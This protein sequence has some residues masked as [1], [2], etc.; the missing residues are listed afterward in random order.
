MAAVRCSEEE[1]EANTNAIYDKCRL[2]SVY[3]VDPPTS[4]KQTDEISSMIQKSLTEREMIEI[5]CGNPN[6]P[7]K[8]QRGNNNNSTL[9]SSN[10]LQFNVDHHPLRWD[11]TKNTSRKTVHHHPL[12]LVHSSVIYGCYGGMW[13]CDIHKHINLR[14]A[15]MF[16]CHECLFDV[17]I[18][19]ISKPCFNCPPSTCNHTQ[20]K[21][22]LV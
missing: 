6:N 14:P 18:P 4:I 19:C 10:S 8:V 1:E 21:I 11:K 17:C 7:I 16:H 12:Q 9:F 13:R 15:Y 2:F 3:K 5:T 20:I 22:D